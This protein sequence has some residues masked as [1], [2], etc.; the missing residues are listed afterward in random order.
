MSSK[1]LSFFLLV[2][3][4]LS[5]KLYIPQSVKIECVYI[6][7]SHE[8]MKCTDIKIYILYHLVLFSTHAHKILV[9]SKKTQIIKDY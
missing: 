9:S 2:V 7:T 6:S 8:F 1:Y 3:E 5:S 4:R